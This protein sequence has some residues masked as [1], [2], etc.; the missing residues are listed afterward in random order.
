[1]T[2]KIN[3]VTEKIELLRVD[4]NKVELVTSQNSYEIQYLKAVK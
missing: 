4:L 2:T 3:G 1:M